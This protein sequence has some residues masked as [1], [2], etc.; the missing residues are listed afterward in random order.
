[1]FG[2]ESWFGNFPKEHPIWNIQASR[3]ADDVEGGDVDAGD[4]EVEHGGRA[5]AGIELGNI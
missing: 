3:D 2:C 1:M 4:D 5:A